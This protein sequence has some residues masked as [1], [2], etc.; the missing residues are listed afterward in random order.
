MLQLEAHVAAHRGDAAAAAES[1]IAMHRAG[2]S[3]EQEPV[4]VSQLIR[5]AICGLAVQ[6][7][8][9]LLPHVEFSD[10]DTASGNYRSYL[11]D[12]STIDQESGTA[13]LTRKVP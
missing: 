3:L 10:S 9:D 13:K 2:Q 7:M 8:A 6:T 11:R 12:A 5:I 4:V 1:L